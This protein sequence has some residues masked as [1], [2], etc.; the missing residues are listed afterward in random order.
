MNE[1]GAGRR[2]GYGRRSAAGS[3]AATTVAGLALLAGCSSGGAPA[4]S[5]SSAGASTAP[6]S[7][8][9]T[10][11]AAASTAPANSG[12]PNSGPPNSGP[13]SVAPTAPQ[14]TGT[15]ASGFVPITEPWDSGIPARPATT[16]GRCGSQTSTLAIEKCYEGKTETA[17]AAIDTSRMAA[18]D[19]ATA[20]QRPGINAADAAWLSARGTVCRLAYQTG[21]TI[22][23]VNTAACLLAESTARLDALTGVASPEAVLKSTDSTSLSDVSWYTT[24]AGSRIGLIDTQGDATGG[25]V[26]AWVIIAGSD[27]F[28][29]NPAQF[30]YRDG[31]FTDAGK[32][33]PGASP[34]GHRV[35][36]GT[37]YQFSVDYSRLASDPGRAKGAGGWVYAPGH[38]AAVWR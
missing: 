35:A 2:P 10:S 21:G 9:A 7:P 17:D 3:A 4:A 27:G 6:A 13:A 28:T 31:S 19:K 1:R 12:P 14:A 16:P 38:P 29:V 18:Y 24:P 22:D 25:I 8:A 15:T 32:V 23:G 36:P 26:I 11:S 37:Q 34:G 20:A 30:A 33:Q 5:T